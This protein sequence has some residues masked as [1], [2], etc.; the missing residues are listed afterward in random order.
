MYISLIGPHYYIFNINRITLIDITLIGP[1][2]IYT[3]LIGP[4]L[5]I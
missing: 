4:H 5:Y 2:K 1:H 3:S